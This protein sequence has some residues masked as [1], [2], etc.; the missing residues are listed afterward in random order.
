MPRRMK[1]QHGG[2]RDDAPR[3]PRPRDASNNA[4]RTEPGQHGDGAAGEDRESDRCP[5][6][7]QGAEMGEQP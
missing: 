2:A 7:V 1:C 4:V 3:R 6:S 5:E